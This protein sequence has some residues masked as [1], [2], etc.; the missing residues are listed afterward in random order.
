MVNSVREL[1]THGL[2]Q[3]RRESDIIE[4]VVL[5]GVEIISCRKEK[6][7]T[8]N[9]VVCVCVLEVWKVAICVLSNSGGGEYNKVSAINV[10]FFDKQGTHVSES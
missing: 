7:P 6:L 9:R 1:K 2:L 10:W 4:A 8:T 5:A 3:V